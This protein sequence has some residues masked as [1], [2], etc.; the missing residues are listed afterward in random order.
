M[1]AKIF[2]LAVALAMLAPNAQAATAYDLNNL[3]LSGSGFIAGAISGIEAVQL[4]A[5]VDV[6]PQPGM[7]AFWSA[8][9]QGFTFFTGTTTRF[10]IG[11]AAIGN[12]APHCGGFFL[13]PSG[14][15]SLNISEAARTITWS[16]IGGGPFQ[17]VLSFTPHVSIS[18]A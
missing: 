17:G 11:A 3:P 2:A 10:S 12:C 13:P 16:L 4:F 6:V 8:T 18:F 5:R 15:F 1:K 9:L 7:D 14:G